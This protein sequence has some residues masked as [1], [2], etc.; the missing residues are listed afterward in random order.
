MSR[1]DVHRPFWVQHNDPDDRQHFATPTHF[2]W[3]RED[4]DPETRRWLVRRSAPCDLDEPA[5]PTKAHRCSL[6][7]LRN[8]C[9]CQLCTCQYA[10]KRAHRKIRTAWRS[11]RA[12]LLRDP[13]FEPRRFRRLP[14]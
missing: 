3:I 5:S 1:T 11:D 7:P 8:L 2:H 13:D 14:Q 4:W 6:W 10:R 12:R 9:G